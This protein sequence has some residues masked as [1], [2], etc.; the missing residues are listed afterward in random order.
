MRNSLRPPLLLAVLLALVV[1]ACGGGSS[2]S[3]DSVAKV[4]GKEI[5]KTELDALLTQAQ[6][7]YKTQKRPFPKAG[8][9]EYLQLQA[10]ALQFLVQRCQ[11]QQKADEAGVTVAPKKVADRLKQIKKQY[12]GGSEKRYR[13]ELKKQGLTDA[14]VRR[15]IRAQLISE[16]LF[17]QLTDTV[18][19]T[20]A[21]TRAY[22]DEHPEQ[23]ST[24]ESRDVAHILVKKKALADRLY[25]QV[26]G[27]ADFAALAKKHSQDPG[28]KSQGGK[29]TVSK[30]QTV[31]E[32]DKVAF[33]LKTGEIAKPVKTQF[34][35]H[36]I[37]AL[38]A[39]K[40]RKATPYKD[41]KEAIRQ[42]LMSTRRTELIT[43][44]QSDLKKEYEDKI[45]YAKGYEP[46]DTSTT[47]TT[48][49]TTG[50]TGTTT[51]TG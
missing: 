28:S 25:A 17:K 44:W 16:A 7:S 35:F 31:A 15:D 14:Q 48:T 46:P 24:P 5:K 51:T 12:F 32:F 37:K 6:K 2:L 41:V 43:K 8:S 3:K 45:T 13:A 19:I 9:P 27:G 36:V 21:Q 11:Y 38:S 26:K 22:Y 20:E 42:Q 34:G 30:G 23:Y 10:Q 50:T 49:G 39:I 47:G 33:S 4:A 40:P 18:K 1:S 29:L